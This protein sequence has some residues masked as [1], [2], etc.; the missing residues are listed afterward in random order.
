LEL[1]VGL[2][3]SGSISHDE[4][5]EF[6]SE[7]IGIANSYRQ[8]KMRVIAWACH[9]DE[10]DDIEVTGDT[11][12]QLM[13]CKFYGGGGTELSCLTRY[14]KQ[15]D[16]KTRL[17]VILTDGYIESKPDLPD[18]VDCLFVLSRNGTSDVIQNY[19]DVTSLNDSS[20]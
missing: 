8:V 2:D 20:R 16:Y 9:V 10:R 14:I 5:V 6:M 18:G 13:K 15:R 3:I 4:Y 12:D 7:V 11:Q 19:G 17:M 1:I